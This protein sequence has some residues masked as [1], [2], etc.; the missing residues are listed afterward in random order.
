MAPE[1]IKMKNA[2]TFTLKSDVYAYGI[3]LFEIFAQQLP[4]RK[5]DQDN[6]AISQNDSVSIS[7]L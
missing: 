2:D 1:V 7:S 4:Y 5:N 6:L 3:V